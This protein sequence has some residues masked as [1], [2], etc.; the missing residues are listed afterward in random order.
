[1]TAL[2]QTVELGEGREA[3]YEVIGE[4]APLLY[5]Q[6]G[7]GFSA[8]LYTADPDRPGVRAMIEE[9]RQD[10]KSDLAAVKAWESGLWQTIDARPL[11]AKIQCPTLVLVG[12]LDM[13]CGP[14]Q[15]RLIAD[16]VPG[17]ELVIVPGSGHFIAAEAPEAFREEIIKFAS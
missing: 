1:M 14:T 3:A 6:G 9:W 2:S 15:G 5:F 17:A 16:A 10:M 12:A 11:L 7:P 8:A 13:I 4:G